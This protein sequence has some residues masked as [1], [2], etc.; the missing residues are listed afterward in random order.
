MTP[1]LKKEGKVLIY[2]TIT[3]SSS[4]RRST[5][6]VTSGGGGGLFKH[7]HWGMLQTKIK[8]KKH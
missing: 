2:N 6:T 4:L 3:F 8:S 1:L 7:P 5:P